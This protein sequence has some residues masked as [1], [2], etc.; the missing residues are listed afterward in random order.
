MRL[1]L[2]LPILGL[3]W[4]SYAQHAP[5]T[6]SDKLDSLMSAYH[7]L[8]R[9]NGSVLVFRQ[10]D[11]LL[12]EAYGLKNAIEGSTNTPE[13]IFRIYSTT[14]TF[15]STLILRLVE[16]HRLSLDDSLSK[17]FPEIPQA[18]SITIEHLLTHTSGLYEFTRGYDMPDQSEKSFITFLKNKPLDFSPGTNW[19]YC[20]TGYWLLGLIIEKIS[21]MPYETAVQTMIFQP[22]RMTHSGFDFKYF[23]NAD[24]ATGYEMLTG[25]QTKEAE[26]YE[27]PG[28]YAAGAIH[29]TVDDLL[30]YHQGLQHEEIISHKSLEKAYTPVQ[31][32]YG[33]GWVIN[34]YDGHRVVSHG[35]GGA[36]FH[37]NFA[38]IP[39]LDICI[40]LL[41]NTEQANLDFI[42]GKILDILFGKEVILPH[43][44]KLELPAL[45][46]YVGTFLANPYFTMYV[47]IENGRLTAQVS[48]QPKTILL[49]HRTNYFYAEE[50]RG[51][52]EF[53]ETGS[54]R[55]DT[56]IIH[57]G[58]QHI[59]AQ[60][61]FPSWGVIGDAL[62]KG[63]G[64]ALPDTPLTEDPDKQGLWTLE[65]I[66]LQKGEFKFRFNNDWQFN[67]GDN[68]ADQLLDPYGENIRIDAGT[69]RIRLDLREKAAP[70]YELER[71]K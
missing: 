55:Y 10:G 26:V 24:K 52:L 25:Q 34:E 29:S 8:D 44:I 54:G 67:Y 19:S 41:D 22:L 16:E 7:T 33:Y 66:E 40:V 35:G 57:Q 47:G 37:S 11:T 56:L 48:G 13:T 6:I 38:R 71:L 23:E 3:A 4:A 68:N 69:Y 58:N 9:F 20:N 50:A 36:G 59:P 70:R 31:N 60:R 62:A 27:P 51:F 49:A 17:F 5:A 32:N 15:T 28:P 30:K 21:A 1:L 42:T 63:W 18:D 53:P 45:E 65:R 2:L 39:E 64:D 61:I 12:R 14:K 43:E 46:R